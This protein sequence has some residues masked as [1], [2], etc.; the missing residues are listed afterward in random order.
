MNQIQNIVWVTG[1]HGFIGRVLCG[2]LKSMGYLVGG[3]G[4]GAWPQSY[5]RRAGI[6]AWVN[7][8]ISTGNLQLL[9]S[10]LGVPETIFHLAGG[11]SVGAAIAQPKEDFNKT[12]GA[13]LEV[14]EWVRENQVKTRV[15]L[16]SSAA[17]YGGAHS[18]PIEVTAQLMPYSP[19][20]NHKLIMEN[21]CRSYG[22]SYD[23][24]SVIGRLFSVYGPGLKKQLLWD[25]CVKAK[26]ESNS[27]ELDG[28]GEEIRDWVHVN[29]AVNSLICLAPLAS[30]ACKVF[31]LGSGVG[32]SVREI[33]KLLLSFFPSIGG[34]VKAIRFTGKVRRGDPFSLIA[35]DPLRIEVPRVE[36]SSGIQDYV[37]W[38]LN[39]DEN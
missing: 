15:V 2:R 27:I 10:I 20:G 32:T 35:S 21:L 6:E 26:N 7:G 13:A 1:A 3:I 24:S 38:Y 39:Q 8:D 16:V 4:H 36:L 37:N 33:A 23:I 5:Y 9:K 14:F 11:S 22:D 29:D 18:G 28:T 34:Q 19:Y 17:V 12:V 31:N 30:P 25:L